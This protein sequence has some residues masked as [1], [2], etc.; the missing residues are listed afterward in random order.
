MGNF[1]STINNYRLTFDKMIWS[2]DGTTLKGK[3]EEEGIVEC[4]R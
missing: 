1:L 3:K 4:F 2:K